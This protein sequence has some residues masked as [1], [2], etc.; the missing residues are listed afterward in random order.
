M[1]TGRVYLYMS[2]TIGTKEFGIK[3]GYKQATV[4]KW[5]REG[6]I[7]GADQEATVDETGIITYTCS[8]CGDS[9][10]ETI[11]K[12]KSDWSIVNEVD[13]FGDKTS[14]ENVS[15]LFKGSFSNSATSGS[16]L[17]VY[18]YYSRQY[19]ETTLMYLVEYGSHPAMFDGYDTVT[20]EIKDDNGKVSSYNMTSL[21]QGFLASTDKSLSN[22]IKNNKESKI[23]ITAVSKYGS[24]PRTYSFKVNNIGLSELLEKSK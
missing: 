18:V 10:T 14:S 7:P 23:V 8:V 16:D 22:T 9:Y 2:D 6:K 11:D 3:F 19:P 5:C 1:S 13:K 24:T 12:I 20:L 21:S 4:A 15:G 17:H